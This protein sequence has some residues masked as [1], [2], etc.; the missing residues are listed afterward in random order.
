MNMLLLAAVAVALAGLFAFADGLIELVVV[1]VL[2]GIVSAPLVPLADSLTLALS[3]RA[4]FN[5]P[6]GGPPGMLPS[7]ATV[8]VHLP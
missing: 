6:I 2:S 8:A 1:A 3:W 4:R 7:I 5:F